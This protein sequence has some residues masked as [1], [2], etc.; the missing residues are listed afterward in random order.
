[1]K[2]IVKNENWLF[3]EPIELL[4]LCSKAITKINTAKIGDS[5]TIH[6]DGISISV[7]SNKLTYSDLA[8]INKI[9]RRL[10]IENES[11]LRNIAANLGTTKRN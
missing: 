6:N 8:K 10:L 2:A 9:L 5:M 11:E 1:M 3:I 4:E 7:S